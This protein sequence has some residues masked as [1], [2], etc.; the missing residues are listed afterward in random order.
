[1]TSLDMI[2]KTNASR[3][4]KFVIKT[5]HSRMSAMG[6]ASAYAQ[7]KAIFVGRGN[8]RSGGSY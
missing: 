4:R 8:V 5:K 7:A 6:G 2:N 3:F 1:M